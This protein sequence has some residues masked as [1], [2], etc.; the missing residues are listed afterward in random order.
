[1]ADRFTTT[2]RREYAAVARLA[3]RLTGD[4]GEAEDV[5]Q[6]VFGR[7]ADDAVLSRPDDEVRA[8]LWRV[9]TNASLNRLRARRR[10]RARLESAGRDRGPGAERPDDIVVRRAEA[11][12]VRDILSELS[13]RQ[14]E[15]LVLRHS[16]V[17]YADIA[18]VTGLAPSSV[19]TVLA[20][21]ERAFRSA[22]EEADRA[23]LC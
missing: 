1:M 20:R 5:A 21:A 11:G 17:S 8:W 18:A 6:E 14:R 10:E 22:Y 12:H 19:G 15:V 9:T 13:E 2:F 4:A 16:G 23:H 3:R 7:L